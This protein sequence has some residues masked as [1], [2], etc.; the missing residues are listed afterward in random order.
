MTREEFINMPI[1]SLIYNEQCLAVTNSSFSNPQE[2]TDESSIGVDEYFK[3][4][5]IMDKYLNNIPVKDYK[6]W[7]FYSMEAPDKIQIQYLT[8]KL[9]SLENFVRTRLI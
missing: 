8:G 7:H 4:L 5:G 9:L 2:A 1:N 3:K 6:N